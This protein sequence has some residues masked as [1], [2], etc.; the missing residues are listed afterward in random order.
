MLWICLQTSQN[1]RESECDGGGE[2]VSFQQHPPSCC[3]NCNVFTENWEWHPSWVPETYIHTSSVFCQKCEIYFSMFA[4]HVLYFFS[5]QISLNSLFCPMPPSHPV[6]CLRPSMQFTA[7]VNK[8]RWTIFRW[9]NYRASWILSSWVQFLSPQNSKR[10]RIY[11]GGDGQWKHNVWE[12]GKREV[13]RELLPSQLGFHL[14][15]PTVLLLRGK[16][17]YLKVW[18]T[19]YWCINSTMFFQ[20]YKQQETEGDW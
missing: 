15:K 1:H 3:E 18:L 6:K 12:R 14:Q 13:I 11:T 20:A 2:F 17:V 16:F 8:Q 10:G 5:S 7:L 9:R 19:Y 4:L